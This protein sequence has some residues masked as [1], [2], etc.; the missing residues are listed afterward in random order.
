M[1]VRTVKYCLTTRGERN[2]MKVD[3]KKDRGIL[4]GSW[5]KYSGRARSPQNDSGATRLDIGAAVNARLNREYRERETA[6][7]CPYLGPAGSDAGNQSRETDSC[8][9]PGRTVHAG[10]R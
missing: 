3:G 10:G 8:W 1:L 7:S 5:L 2:Y 6:S 9:S 4:R